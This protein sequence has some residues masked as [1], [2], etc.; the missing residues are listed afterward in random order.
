MVMSLADFLLH[1]LSSS[2]SSQ[3]LGPELSVSSFVLII[4]ITEFKA[5]ACTCKLEF[6]STFCSE[7]LKI[8]FHKQNIYKMEMKRFKIYNLCTFCSL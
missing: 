7:I 1:A 2:F 4:H 5:N 8:H 6:Y 3:N